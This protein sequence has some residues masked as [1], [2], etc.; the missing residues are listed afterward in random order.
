MLLAD[1]Q[2]MFEDSIAPRGRGS[3][4]G[5]L[6]AISVLLHVAVLAGLLLATGGVGA[7]GG[8]GDRP[9]DVLLLP[10]PPAPDPAA[11][12]P[13]AAE[14]QAAQQRQAMLDHLV[15]PT[16]VPDTPAPGAA[17]D[18]ATATR[19]GSAGGSSAASAST[20]A[21][22][23]LPADAGGSVSRP[24]IIDSTR[25]LPDYPAAAQRAGLEGMVVVK[26]VIDEQGRVGDVQ[27]LRGLGLGLDEAA[28]AAVRHW[29]FHPATRAGKPV[30]VNYVLSVYFRL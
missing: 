16:A 4:G 23:D 18:P 8:G 20:A 2:S 25:T 11:A 6:L 30:K 7:D 5:Q 14:R 21:G 22:A 15:Q 10:A 17:T 26:A 3:S 12:P 13:T 19:S 29:R 28:V 1:A 9:I 27:V 24:V